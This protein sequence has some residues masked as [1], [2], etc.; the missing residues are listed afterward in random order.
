MKA[1]QRYNKDLSAWEY[2]T[3]T[4]LTDEQ[5]RKHVR[6]LR[7]WAKDAGSDAKYRVKTIILV[8]K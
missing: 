3:P 2:I 6:D 1:I 8:P 4:P 7:R 5:A